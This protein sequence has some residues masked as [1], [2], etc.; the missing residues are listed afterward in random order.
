MINWSPEVLVG[1]LEQ[2]GEKKLYLSENEVQQAV[3]AHVYL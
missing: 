1:N 3:Q 2:N